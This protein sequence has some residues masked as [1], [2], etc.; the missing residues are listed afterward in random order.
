MSKG[1]QIIPVRFPA[2]LLQLVDAVVARSADKRPEGPWTR[3][4]F[5]LKAVEDKLQHMLR[6]RRPKRQRPSW[7][8]SD[9]SGD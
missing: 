4:S 8:G 2:H 5:I 6:S 7:S 1:S 9:G 3:S